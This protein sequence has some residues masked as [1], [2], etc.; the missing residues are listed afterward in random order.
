MLNQTSAAKADFERALQLEPCA[1]E[2]RLNALRMG[3]HPAPAPQCRYSEE[4]RIALE[5][6]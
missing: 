5:G 1:F 3:L 4:E 6:K 2:A